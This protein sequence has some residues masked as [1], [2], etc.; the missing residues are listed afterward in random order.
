[1]IDTSLC[2]SLP[3]FLW[4]SAASRARVAQRHAAL[5]SPLTHPRARRSVRVL[6]RRRVRAQPG[7]AD[8]RPRAGPLL[9]N[10]RSSVPVQ[11]TRE[12]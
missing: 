11:H 12:A 4:N 3:T 6:Q 10:P 1:M 5:R 9:A 7:R 8:L 2:S